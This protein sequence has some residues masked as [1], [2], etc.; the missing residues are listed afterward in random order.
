ML[1]WKARHLRRDWQQQLF[2]MNF[3]KRR[4]MYLG[5]IWDKY[6]QEAL[7]EILKKLIRRKVIK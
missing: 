6:G 3:L 1:Q 7:H 4:G 5:G 2:L